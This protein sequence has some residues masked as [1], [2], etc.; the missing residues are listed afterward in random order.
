M[1]RAKHFLI[2]DTETTGIGSKAIVYDFAYV[3]ATRKTVVL[4][5]SFLVKEIITNPKIMLGAID[6][7]YWRQSFGGKI[8][9][10]YIPK[11]NTNELKLFNWREIVETLRDDMQTYDVDVFAAY[12][13][14][15]DMNALAKTHNKIVETGKVLDYKP[16]LL[17]LWEFACST[18]CRSRLY[19]D[20]ARERGIES[21]WVT[22]ANNIRTT[23]EK[24]YAY[25]SGDLDFI[26][27][28]TAIEDCRI[29]TEIMQ[30]LLAKKT[31]IP[32]NVVGHMPWRRAQKLWGNMHDNMVQ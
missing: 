18:V 23:A 22:Q 7:K 13:L 3:I 14:N 15:F 16:D 20:I 4:E 8:F 5:R 1:P 28:H 26:E 12:N 6:D 24:V 19:H 29:E 31:P 9:H 21:G 11:L 30:R 25:L 32:Y 17:C 27:S 2:A 10:H